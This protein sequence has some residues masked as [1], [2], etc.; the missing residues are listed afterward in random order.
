MKAGMAQP[1]AVQLHE[2]GSTI[3]STTNLFDHSG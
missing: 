2:I 3:A 1:A